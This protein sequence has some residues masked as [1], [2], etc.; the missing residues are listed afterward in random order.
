M[1]Y[2]QPSQKLVSKERI[3]TKVKKKHDIAKT[4]CQRLISRQDV[5]EQTKEALRKR[6]D[7]LNVAQLLRSIEKLILELYQS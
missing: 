7:S 3:G 2:F 1:G 6:F 5:P 4:P